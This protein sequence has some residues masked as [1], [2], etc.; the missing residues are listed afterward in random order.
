[1]ECKACDKRQKNFFDRHDSPL[2]DLFAVEE[3]DLKIHR[4]SRGFLRIFVDTRQ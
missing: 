1:V 2:P 3:D 4:K